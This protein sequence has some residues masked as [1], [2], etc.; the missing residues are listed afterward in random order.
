[1]SDLDLINRTINDARRER[2]RFIA[3]LFAH[4][5]ARLSGRAAEGDSL[6][7]RG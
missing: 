6:V 1:M 4:L 3:G 2:A 7:R 5:L